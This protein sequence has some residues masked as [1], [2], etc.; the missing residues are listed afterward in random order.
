MARL[1][2]HTSLWSRSDKENLPMKKKQDDA[3]TVLLEVLTD[4]S[5][6]LTDRDDAAINLGQYDEDRVLTTLLEVASDP[7][8]EELVLSSAGESIAQIW[9]RCRR[10]DVDKLTGLQPIA[11]HEAIALLEKEMP[12]SIA[13]LNL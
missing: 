13:G 8:E 7:A 1:S 4:K 9:L 3:I 12:S 10:V 5:A 2:A 6:S 11:K